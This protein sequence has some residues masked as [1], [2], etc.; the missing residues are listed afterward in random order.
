MLRLVRVARLGRLAARYPA[1][2]QVVKALAQSFE[3]IWPVAI[4]LGLFLFVFATL[5]MQ[6]FADVYA[7]DYTRFDNFWW[8]LLQ[9]FLV[10]VGENWVSIMY[11]VTFE[12][13]SP[14]TKV[15]FFSIVA[16]RGQAIISHQKPGFNFSFKSRRNRSEV[17][18]EIKS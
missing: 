17:E 13:G 10:F 2:V 15:F 12:S 5:G 3:G 16:L 4:L 1:I 11:S 18:C 9:T 6:L 7:D 8:S 14:H